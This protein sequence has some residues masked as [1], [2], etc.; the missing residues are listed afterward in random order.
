[1]K[2]AIPMFIINIS[3][4]FPNLLNVKTKLG[5]ILEL[6]VPSKYT[7][8]DKL[9]AGHQRRKVINRAQGKGFGYGLFNKN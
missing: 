5:N 6:N 4:E 2:L 9:W 8:S 1:M 3:F 7:I